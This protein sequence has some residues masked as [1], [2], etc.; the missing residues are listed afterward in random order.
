M[1]FEEYSNFKKQVSCNIENKN[2]IS[3]RNRNIKRTGIRVYKDGYI[4]VAGANGNF[5]EEKLKTL[6]MDELKL[7]YYY[8]C[9][10]SCN[11][12]EFMRFKNLKLENDAFLHEME[13]IFIEFKKINPD[14]I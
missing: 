7:K 9:A 10:P 12:Y 8:P 6:A 2:F 5:D 11:Y 3:V 14:F 13:E 1:V 4:G